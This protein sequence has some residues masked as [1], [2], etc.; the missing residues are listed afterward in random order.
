MSKWASARQIAKG[1]GRATWASAK[2]ATR[3][4]GAITRRGTTAS[5]ATARAVLGGGRYRR[6]A[7]EVNQRIAQALAV[8][9]AGLAQRDAHI[10]ELES[11]L[12]RCRCGV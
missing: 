3:A 9:D 12:A 7:E 10:A 6:S 8:A 5:A 11:R 1:T 4:T 2:V